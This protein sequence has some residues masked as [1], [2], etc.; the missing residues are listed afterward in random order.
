MK[1]IAIVTLN[2]YFNYG[3]RLQNYA[4]QEVL[5]SFG[6]KVETLMVDANKDKQQVNNNFKNIIGTVKDK[7]LKELLLKVESKIWSSFNKNLVNNLKL[8]RTE[9][10]KEFTK[11]FINETEFVI[12][13]NQIPCGLGEDYD[14][15]ITGSDQVW[16]PNYILGSSIYFLTFAPREK[17]VAFSPSFGVSKIPSEHQNNYRQWLSEMEH[18]SVREDAG[19][20][21]I[22]DLTNRDA[23]V[24]SDPTMMLTREQWL[25]ISTKAKNI[26]HKK[27]LLTYFLGNL[28]IEYQNEINKIAKKNKLKIINLSNLRDRETYQTGPSEFIEYINSASVFCTDSFHGAVF[29]ILL[30]TP[31]IVFQR[32]GNSPSM[33]SR[34]DTL[35]NKFDFNSRKFSNITKNEEIFDIEFS[36]VPQ[37]LEQERNKTRN[38]LLNSLG[39]E[40]KVKLKR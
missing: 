35:L 34:I 26:D 25:S 18:L 8:N 4:V 39:V 20:K 2:G 15:F 19:A 5:K 24:L 12:S 13:D 14:Y 29:S 33:Y 37:I 6:L 11:S 38:Y 3:N 1:K 7:T 30:E 31:F 10:F 36:H 16:N 28:S 23:L 22:K 40:M 17:R 9:I 21:I 32:K 27:Y